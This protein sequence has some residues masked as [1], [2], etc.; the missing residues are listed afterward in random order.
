MPT[1]RTEVAA[2]ALGKDIFVIGGFS[3]ADGTTDR[4]EIYD[5][6]DDSWS[7]GAR[8]PL[9]VNHGM[10]TSHDGKVYVAGGYAGP[11]VEDPTARAF[12]GDA[13]GW[14]SLPRMPEARA[15]GAL[16]VVDGKLY[17]VGGVGP[18]GLAQRTFVYDPGADKWRT[19][20]GLRFARQHLGGAGA[21][22]RVYVVGG[23][24][25]GLDSN[26]GRSERYAPKKRRWARIAP[27]PTPR[28]GLAATATLGF[29]V[30]AGGEAE[31]TFDE[32]EAF[33]VREKR[34]RRLPNM[35]TAR[36]GLGIVAVGS[37][38]YVLAGG[39]EPGLTYS[40]ANEA[41]DL[42]PLRDR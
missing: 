35:P 17:V 39:P 29:V 16:V 28:G 20:P 32:V 30:A 23:R 37:V 6:A 12:V 11:G 4:V 10:A 34:W 22:S 24:T 9:A 15:A 2:A 27:M 33:D 25:Q 18:D 21:R 7:E 1:P 19:R 38:V 8:L 26:T 5:T 31:A 41:L 3:Q 42:A 14:R 36:H 13:N 40:G